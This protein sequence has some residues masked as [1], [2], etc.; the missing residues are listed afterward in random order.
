MRSR[1]VSALLLASTASVAACGGV[2]VSTPSSASGETAAP[3]G[4]FA[5]ATPSALTNPNK[6]ALKAYFL[7]LAEGEESPVALVPVNRDVPATESVMTTAIEQL[8]VGP[9][10]DESTPDSRGRTIGTRIPQGTRLLGVAI[11]DNVATVDLSGEF[12][13]GDILERDRES[14]AFRLAQVTYTL[15]QFST[16]ESVR[17]RVDGKPATAIEGHEGTPIARATRDAY[18]DQRPGIFVDQPAWGG[19]LADPLTVSGMAQIDAEPPQFQAGLVDRASGTIVV[20]QT[21]RAPCEA[22]CWQPPGGGEFEVRLLFPA[23]A[24]RSELLL[25]V[26]ESAPDGRQVNLLEYP[27]H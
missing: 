26:W 22:G 17:F 6:V 24:T 11:D 9:I 5:S 8:L 15:T 23:G 25:R 10:S 16:I 4:T 12:A 3:G 1:L 13:S 2:G 7:L 27:L 14:W 20:Q 19:A 18:A 21:V